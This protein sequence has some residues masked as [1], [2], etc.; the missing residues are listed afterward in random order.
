[1]DQ[2]VE[3]LTMA[4]EEIDDM[5]I[6]ECVIESVLA[7]DWDEIVEC[8]RDITADQVAEYIPPY[9]IFFGTQYF[10][11]DMLVSIILDRLDIQ[12]EPEF[13]FF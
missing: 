12:D 6:E 4:Y 10:W 8:L 2:L 13:G 5:D 7:L 3:T 11:R 9:Y 1:M